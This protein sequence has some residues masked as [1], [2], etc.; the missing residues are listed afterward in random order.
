MNTVQKPGTSNSSLGTRLMIG[1]SICC[2]ISIVLIYFYVFGA[3]GGE[4]NSFITPNHNIRGYNDYCT[5]TNPAF[6]S[7][8]KKMKCSAVRV[9][10]GFS[11]KDMMRIKR[12]IYF[13]SYE[14]AYVWKN[15]H[16][17]AYMEETPGIANM[18]S[19]IPV[20]DLVK[21]CMVRL[22]RVPPDMILLGSM[23]IISENPVLR[24]DFDVVMHM[25][26]TE[27]NLI[28]R[29]SEVG[30]DMRDSM[31]AIHSL[32]TF[33]RSRGSVGLSDFDSNFS[34]ISR[35]FSHSNIP[36]SSLVSA[37]G[38]T[39]HLMVPNAQEGEC[40]EFIRT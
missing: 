29:M 34:H 6:S 40:V 2:L 19:E 14:N 5:I 32:M 36:F 17:N 3:V 13:Y 4:R 35:L 18:I 1:L 12:T 30:D 28:L 22:S 10:N 26:E 24:D 8:L 7:E 15:A 25:N 23:S 11:G 38:Q 27:A 37:L 21:P 33:T 31:E 16:S 20:R 9:G 39:L